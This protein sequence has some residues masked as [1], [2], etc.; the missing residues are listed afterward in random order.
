MNPVTLNPIGVVRSPYQS[1]DQAP[2]QGPEAGGQSVIALDPGLAPGLSGLAP[3]RD[4]WVICYFHQTPGSKL[5]A[6]PR[7]DQTRPLTGIFN[8]RSPKRPCPL[9]LTLVRLLDVCLSPEGPLLIV[10]GLEAIDGTPVLD[11]KPYAPDLDLP[12]GDENE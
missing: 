7:G 11:L 3:G 6:H 9:S 2:H 1:P 4:L 12:R 5:L 10:R 8:T